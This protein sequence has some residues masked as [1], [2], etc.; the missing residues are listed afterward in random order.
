MDVYAGYLS[1]TEHYVGKFT[2][3]NGASAEGSLRRDYSH[4]RLNAVC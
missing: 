4:L 3:D 2:D 1:Y